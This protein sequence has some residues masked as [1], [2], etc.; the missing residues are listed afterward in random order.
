MPSASLAFCQSSHMLGHHPPHV[1]PL[2]AARHST[3]F[4]AS[5]FDR[6]K[7]RVLSAPY[8]LAAVQLLWP[9]SHSIFSASGPPIWQSPWLWARFLSATCRGTIRIYQRPLMIPALWQ[10]ERLLAVRA[11]IQTLKSRASTKSPTIWWH[12]RL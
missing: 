9:V 2:Y 4:S 3:S 10:W 5:A 1:S 8:L 6:E 11:S 7:H 12:Y